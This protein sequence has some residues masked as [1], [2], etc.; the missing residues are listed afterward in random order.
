MVALLLFSFTIF[1][2]KNILLALIAEL[3]I[4]K[5]Y[6]GAAMSVASFFA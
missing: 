3:A 6:E 1:I 2:A 5:Q 4:I